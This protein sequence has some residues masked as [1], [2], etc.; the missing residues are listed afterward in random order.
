MQLVI[1]TRMRLWWHKLPLSENWIL[2]AAA[3]REGWRERN[4]W[5]KLKEKLAEIAVVRVIKID[6][7]PDESGFYDCLSRSRSAPINNDGSL[8]PTPHER[9]IL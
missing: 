4:F 7:S 3:L 1:A 5:I 2:R 6:S 9:A 8:H